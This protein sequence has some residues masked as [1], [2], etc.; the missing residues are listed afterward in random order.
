MWKARHGDRGALEELVRKQYPAVHGFAYR[1]LGNPGEAHDAAKET[2]ARVLR[3]LH[4]HQES[5]SF[6]ARVFANAST[7]IRDI[8]RKRRKKLAVSEGVAESVAAGNAPDPIIGRDEEKK[9]IRSGFNRVPGDSKLLL[10]LVFQQ[11]LSHE[12]VAQVIGISV[13]AVRIRLSSALELLRRCVRE[14][15]TKEAS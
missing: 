6:R 9:L 15:P 11:G 13:T 2:F 7:V 3:S 1:M 10:L 8:Y 4:H 12:E 5:L 14:E